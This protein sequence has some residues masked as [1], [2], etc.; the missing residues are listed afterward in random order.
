VSFIRASDDIG[1]W[2]RFW[3]V[4]REKRTDQHPRSPRSFR[5]PRWAAAQIA[6]RQAMNARDCGCG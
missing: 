3:R 5:M 2:Y 1:F 4:Y 6:W